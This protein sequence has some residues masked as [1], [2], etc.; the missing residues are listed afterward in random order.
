MAGQETLK[1]VVL[2]GSGVLPT[3][4]DVVAVSEPVLLSPI[5]A[6]GT[7]PAIG[8]G[9]LANDRGYVDPD[10][11][12]AEF[13]INTVLR[14]PIA[15]GAACEISKL[16]KLAGLAETLTATTSAVYKPGGITGSGTGQVKVFLDGF[17][18]LVTGAS[19]TL[20]ITGKMGEPIKVSFG[21]K[22]SCPAEATAEA[23]PTVTLNTGAQIVLT[24]NNTV[25]TIAGAAISMEDFEL[26]LGIELKRTYTSETN[27]F[28]I[29]NLKPKL[30]I[31]AVKTKTTDEAAWTQFVTGGLSVINLTAG[32]AGN[33]FMLDVPKAFSEAPAE[34]DKDGRVMMKRVFTLENGGIANNNFTITLK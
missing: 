8:T 9:A 3:A 12:T 18:R 4:T 33:Q 34:S 27:E 28:Y 1:N 26:D 22:G 21:V 23:N 6:T 17:S 30:S 7:I 11:S 24:K 2:V 15:L 5:V 25:L 31:T 20:K 10:N 16:L 13:N 32:A 29:S 19:A 14:S